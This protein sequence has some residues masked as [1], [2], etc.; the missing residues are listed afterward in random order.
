[1]AASQHDQQLAK[2]HPRD[3]DNASI[4]V[5][6]SMLNNRRLLTGMLPKRR[7]YE[8]DEPDVV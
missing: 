1:M 5:R 3:S 2:K 8:R 7:T 4:K 6:Q